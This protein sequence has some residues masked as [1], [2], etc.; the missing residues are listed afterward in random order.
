MRHIESEIPKVDN[1]IEKQAITGISK[2]QEWILKGLNMWYK[3]Q[4][5][6]FATKEEA[7]DF[8]ADK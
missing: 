5:Y 8:L 2:I 1:L 6:N 4:I 7:L 3:R